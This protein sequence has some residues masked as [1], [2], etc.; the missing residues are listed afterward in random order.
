MAAPGTRFG[1]YT[2]LGPLGSGGMG[3][4][5]LASDS[6][7]NREVALKFLPDELSHDPDQLARF[8][9]E[10]LALAS[11]NHPNI[12]IIH[13]LEETP[14]GD[15]YLVLERVEGET[16]AARLG[17][18]RLPLE[19][20]LSVCGQLAEALDAAHE[21][22]VIHRDLKPGNLMVTPRGRV[23]VLDFGLARR[24]GE[25]APG[26]A[27]RE[28]AD[29]EDPGEAGLVMG[30]PGYMSPEQAV[31]LPHDHRTDLFS[32][33]C[34]LYECLSGRRAFPGG[35]A[36][37]ITAALLNEDPD[38]GAL[39]A[40]LPGPLD[41]LLR[42]CLRKDPGGRPASATAVCAALAAA[43][44][45]PAPGAPAP[46]AIP[47]NLPPALTSFVGREA[48]AAECLR[49]VGQA[50]LLTL[51]GAGGCGKTR[52]GLHLAGRLLPE[53]PHG[54]WFV[55]LAPLSDPERV[56][57]AVAAAL[58]VRE[59]PGRTPLEALVEHFRARRTLL[60]LDNCEH[61]LAACVSLTG[62]LL[63]A[64][65]GLRVLATSREAL[66]MPGEQVYAVP[67]LA[68]PGPG[69]VRD[70]SGAAAFESVRLFVERAAL[71]RPDFVLDDAG[72]PAVAEICRRLDGIPL[73]LELAAARV[74][75][76]TVEQIRARLDDRFRLLT[77]G[78]RSAL[79]RH[80]TLR[81]TIQWSYD[82][83]VD[84]EQHLLRALSVFHGGWSLE[85]A[86]RV[87][88]GAADEFEVLDRITRLVD[89]S[90]VV[91]E[92]SRAED[93]RYRFLET[94][95]QYAQEKLGESGEGEA[96]RARHLECF[97]ALAAMA[98]PYLRGHDQAQWLRRLELEHEN[99]LAALD[100]CPH[101]A[102][103]AEQAL[104]LSGSL[105]RFWYAHG[106]FRLGR[107]LL[108]G[109]LQGT[110]AASPARAAAL[111]GAGAMAYVQGDTQ[112]ARPVYQELLEVCRG[113]GDRLGVARALNGLGLVAQGADDAATA[114]AR[115]EESLAA[116]REV[117]DQAG[118][119]VALGNLGNLALQQ[120]DFE[121]ARGHFEEG[122]ALCRRLDNR[123]G[124]AA[125]VL[126]LAMAFTRLGNTGQARAS[127]GEGLGLVVELGQKRFGAYALECAA[128]LA[129]LRGEPARALRWC[130]AAQ[131]LREQIGSPLPPVE[132]RELD[133]LV[134][135]LRALP[136]FC[137]P[138]EA[139]AAG[140]ALSFAA[141]LDDVLAWV[142]AGPP[143]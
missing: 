116:Y 34:I 74:K 5:Y 68:V 122:L 27:G 143:G 103:G 137:D 60:A 18:G 121:A 126:N 45:A 69:A 8:Q 129:A 82:Q 109:A 7:L 119:S 131:A 29:A 89:K 125:A 120:R 87:L 30:T 1:S 6:R 110:T 128:G 46:T 15:R 20:T 43:A 79:P 86:A 81:A 97:L 22:G 38:W 114:G 67:T 51:T 83:L 91:V 39:P 33:G 85:T 90:L 100:W 72:A 75:M 2:I 52:L 134:E 115:Y 71:V 70:A 25:A 49:L 53:H 48:V 65:P 19:E 78:S 9:R 17:R 108:A 63:A 21:R 118:M 102:D 105:W 26:N 84:E 31:A 80:Q 3:E 141:A 94:V 138:D 132:Q 124:M 50:R 76:L 135:R 32:F 55:D 130:A 136:G 66:G 92:R 99:L 95:R 107:R 64:C 111:R 41:E 88:P 54:A 77:G 4:V 28:G 11:L 47:H 127:L 58:G 140:A 56:P 112:S 12:A 57:G 61:L 117:G 37:E 73:A 96:V 106:H 14:G 104:R 23:K 35:H 123:E 42:A 36:L 139:W 10:A 98:E 101:S 40:E 44:S 142:A 93:A 16:L 24:G 113:L 13:G 59:E 133:Q 62:A